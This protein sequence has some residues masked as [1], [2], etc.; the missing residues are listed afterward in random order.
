MS[1]HIWNLSV[2]A[3]PPA[4]C[5]CRD[6]ELQTIATEAAAQPERH[7]HSGGATGMNAHQQIAPQDK[8]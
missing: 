5:N 8:Q 6:G 3:L 7:L 4:A 2:I 1:D